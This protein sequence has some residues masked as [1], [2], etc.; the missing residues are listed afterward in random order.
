MFIGEYGLEA[1]LWSA[2]MMLYQLLAGRFPYWPTIEALYSTTLEEVCDRG[3]AGVGGA[4]GVSHVVLH[5]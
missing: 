2:G 3:A 4:Q 1:D 5:A